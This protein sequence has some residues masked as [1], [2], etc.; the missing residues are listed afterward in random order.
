[1]FVVKVTNIL[2]SRLTAPWSPRMEVVTIACVYIFTCVF[3]LGS[4]APVKT[5]ISEVRRV[6]L[7]AKIT[8]VRSVARSFRRLDTGLFS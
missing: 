1:M 3:V 7:G 5:E 6:L 4:A 8:C 2:S